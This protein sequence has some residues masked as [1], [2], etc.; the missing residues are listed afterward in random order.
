M[1][2]IPETRAA[3]RKMPETAAMQK[4]LPGAS[5][6]TN[7]WTNLRTEQKT[8]QKIANIKEREGAAMWRT[9]LYVT[10]TEE[11]LHRLNIRESVIRKEN[12]YGD[13]FSQGN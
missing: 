3:M 8:N 5:L 12:V 9:L 4:I 10:R 7:L 6:R 11:R 2:V 1:R 13:N